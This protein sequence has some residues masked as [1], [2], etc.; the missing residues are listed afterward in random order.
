MRRILMMKVPKRILCLSV[1]LFLI[2]AILPQVAVNAAAA[3]GACGKDVHW[4]LSEDS[5]LTISGTGPMTDY[6]PVTYA[7]WHSVTAS[8]KTI[9]IE[10]GVTT[11]GDL[12]FSN[13]IALE[14]VTIGS[15]VTALGDYAFRYCSS[16]T[17]VTLPEGVTNIRWFAFSGCS[18][19]TSVTFRG[20]APSIDDTSFE[21][22]NAT[23]YYPCSNETWTDA[24]KQNYGGNITWEKCHS[25]ENGT[26]TTCGESE[27]L[28]GDLT[29]DGNI[30][31]MDV[32]KLYAH[33]KGAGSLTDVA[34]LKAAD[35]T[36]DGK[37]NIMDVAKLYA[38][39]KGAN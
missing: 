23:A 26:C 32:A 20:P 8:I 9:V 1:C 39:V 27:I 15:D 29:G 33:V 31:I 3:E 11:V 30:N 5:T 17:T 24:A 21:A 16:L 37:I 12:A 4:S 10:P 38:H 7:P 14:T 28:P 22:V 18:S 36:G 6:T 35:Y 19:L 34:A 2:A 25:Y 13:C